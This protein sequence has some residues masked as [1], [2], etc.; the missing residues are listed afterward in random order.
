MLKV[1]TSPV[2]HN[3]TLLGKRVA[4]DVILVKMKSQWIKEFL[5]EDGHIKTQGEYQVT[6]N[7]D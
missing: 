1:L 7:A 2:P 4:T 5:S 6:T 3:E